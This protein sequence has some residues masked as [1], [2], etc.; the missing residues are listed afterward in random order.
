[1]KSERTGRTFIRERRFIE[2]CIILQFDVN[3]EHIS[4]LHE[5]IKLSTYKHFTCTQRRASVYIC[6]DNFADTGK[7]TQ[8]FLCS[9]F[10]N[11]YFVIRC[12]Q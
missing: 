12:L 2:R 6:Y 11:L 3:A 9:A 4:P 7:T 8:C 1:M 5:I 10:Y